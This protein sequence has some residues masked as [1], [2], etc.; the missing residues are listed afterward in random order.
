MKGKEGEIQDSRLR[1]S[2]K[3]KI[4]S[5]LRKLEFIGFGQG[6]AAKGEELRRYGKGRSQLMEPVP[7]AAE[8][9]IMGIPPPQGLQHS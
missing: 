4:I 7:E 8:G 5:D 2:Q 3:R 6:E 9:S 1:N